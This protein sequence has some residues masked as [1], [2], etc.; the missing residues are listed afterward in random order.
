MNRSAGAPA[1]APRPLEYAYYRGYKR[2]RAILDAPTV[3]VTELLLAHR[4]GERNADALLYDRIYAELHRL[5]H[6]T[7][8]GHARPQAD[9]TS[10][11]HEAYL[12]LAG[13]G[14][15]RASD[16]RHMYALAACAMRQILVDRARHHLALKRGGGADL[17]LDDG[18]AGPA[19]PEHYL[20]VDQA[21]TQ[22]GEIGARLRSVVELHFFVGLGIDEVATLLDISPRS[23]R[24][25][26]QVAR[27]FLA[28]ALQHGDD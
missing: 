12:R 3:D 20:A 11:V 16:R 2:A 6:R 19:R 26:W 25:D 15:D 24:R 22:L 27:A 7:L 21:L 28:R 8:A 23:A 18:F 5:A 10:L 1:N 13:G 14:I 17:S 9:T 4:R